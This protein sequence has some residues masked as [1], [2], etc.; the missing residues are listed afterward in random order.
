MMLQ[1]ICDEGCPLLPSWQQPV[2]LLAAGSAVPS[3]VSC[4]QGSFESICV[5]PVFLSTPAAVTG[6]A[7]AYKF[8]S[9]GCLGVPCPLW[10]Q[11]S[12][13]AA[14]VLVSMLAGYGTLPLLRT[15]WL[16][17]IHA[18]PPPR[19]LVPPG[20]VPGSAVRPIWRV[21]VDG[22]VVPVYTR[23]TLQVCSFS[24]HLL[25][26][27]RAAA[28]SSSEPA[29]VHPHAVGE[30]WLRWLQQAHQQLLHGTCCGAHVCECVC[31]LDTLRDWFEVISSKKG[32]CAAGGCQGSLP[33]DL[34]APVLTQAS[35]LDCRACPSDQQTRCGPP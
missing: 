3:H 17:Y 2:A 8:V 29:A 30:A 23:H 33:A 4:C 34:W 14:A 16:L 31:H 1:L 7:L 10:Q 25:L 27:L 35:M 13:R 28:S 11:H 9:V 5:G 6:V 24:A 12:R 18:F 22:R 15:C 32:G 21:G 20:S 19:L 26:Q